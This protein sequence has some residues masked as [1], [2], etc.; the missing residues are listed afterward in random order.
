MSDKE[1]E[2]KIEPTPKPA[3]PKEIKEDKPKST[4]LSTSRNRR[5][6]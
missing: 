2:P 5:Y 6:N 3:K 4:Q 1:K